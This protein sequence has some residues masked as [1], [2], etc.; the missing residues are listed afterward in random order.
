MATALLQDDGPSEAPMQAAES[1][2]EFRGRTKDEWVT[3]A[4]SLSSVSA[5]VI[6][7]LN[8]DECV[9]IPALPYYVLAFGLASTL[10]GVWEFAFR[11][12]KAKVDKVPEDWRA[13]IGGLIGLSL[14][15][16]AIWGATLTWGRSGSSNECASALYYT[17]VITSAIPLAIVSVIIVV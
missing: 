7:V 2:A 5:V 9:G 17:G 3:F 4:T 6:A 10:N 14:I 8:I 13:H 16:L 12:K 11:L 15:G 1:P